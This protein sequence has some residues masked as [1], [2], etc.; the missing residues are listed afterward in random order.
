[1]TRIK[2]RIRADHLT[3]SSTAD[4]TFQLLAEE[5]LGTHPNPE[6]RDVLIPQ[7]IRLSSYIGDR[8]ERLRQTYE[9]QYNMAIS[10][11]LSERILSAV[12]TSNVA[13]FIEQLHLAHNNMGLQVARASLAASKLSA[14]GVS[15]SSR[16]QGTP[17]VRPSTNSG[18]SAGDAAVAVTRAGPDPDMARLRAGGNTL[19]ANAVNPTL[20]HPVAILNLDAQVLLMLMLI[21]IRL[22]LLLTAP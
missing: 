13:Q 18:K 8:R 21:S 11:G 10:E 4:H 7:I 2:I 14:G 9:F 15:G 22:R 5:V 3:R 19:D 6:D 12:S 17:F 20:T 1:V 16:I